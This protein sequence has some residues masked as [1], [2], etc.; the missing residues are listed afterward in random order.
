ML[1]FLSKVLLARVCFRFIAKI[2]N[3]CINI[4]GSKSFF[5]CRFSSKKAVVRGSCQKWSYF[6]WHH[7]IISRRRPY[8]TYFRMFQVAE[9]VVFLLSSSDYFKKAI[10]IDYLLPATTL[11]MFFVGTVHVQPKHTQKTFF[12]N[13]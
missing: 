12:D 8:D 11:N 4:A 5:C 6:C 2:M 9:V 3:F 7:Q 1:R 13:L 10:I